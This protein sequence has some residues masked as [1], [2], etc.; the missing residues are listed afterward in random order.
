[1]KKRLLA[2]AMF[3]SVANAGGCVLTQSK[4]MSV[5]WKAYKTSLCDLPTIKT[6][7]IDADK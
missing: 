3:Y 6:K 7:S 5:I 2:L 1:M 4:D